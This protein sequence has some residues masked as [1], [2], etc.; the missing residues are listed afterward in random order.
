[1]KLNTMKSPEKREPQ[2]D[3]K[4][5]DNAVDKAKENVKQKVHNIINK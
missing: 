3:A 4:K 2:Y 1:M 5:K